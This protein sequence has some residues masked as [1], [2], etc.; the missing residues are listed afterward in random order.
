MIS[1]RS[2]LLSASAPLLLQGMAQPKQPENLDVL[3]IGAGLAGLN[4][5]MLLEG[6]GAR[7]RVLEA[8][9]RVGGRVRSLTHLEGA[10]EAGGSLIG[11]GYGRLISRAAELG[12][13]LKTDQRPGALYDTRYYIGGKR[14]SLSD[15]EKSD[16]NPFIGTD[17]GTPPGRIAS[18]FSSKTN[19]LT[20]ITDWRLLENA[21]HDRSVY[22]VLAASGFN[23]AQIQLATQIN[24][25]YLGSPHAMSMLMLWQIDA[26][27]KSQLA[28]GR[29]TLGAKGGNDAIP[30]AMAA[31][32]K[33]DVVLNAPVKTISH[34]GAG[35]TVTLHDG[36]V[37][38]ARRCIVTVPLS[39]L[40]FVRFDP[41]LPSV[42][43]AAINQM[44]Y[45]KVVQ[46]HLRPTQPYWERDGQ[47]I[48]MWTDS[49]AGRV[50]GIPSRTGDPSAPPDHLVVFISGMQAAYLDRLP[51]VVAQQHILN[52]LFR[53]RPAMAGAVEP[54][55]FVSWQRDPY[56]GGSYV[57]WGP[58]HIAKFANE[59]IKPFGRIVLAGEH[60][61]RTQR[62]MEGAME[63]GE[64]AALGVLETL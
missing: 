34:D 61:A 46:L 41:V 18:V 16:T 52:E 31:A 45:T 9:G 3:I 6:E 13:E 11:P 8:R 22:E 1:R 37:H 19:P 7:I 20:G 58:G 44:Q 49:G 5:A 63:A 10:P 36:A 32:L 53:L 28:A 2:F 23:D 17:R 27:R 29:V 40:G 55:A 56:A 62:G 59:I 25:A 4:A 48:G 24:P 51:G 57:G 54:V 35:V 26:W 38:K 47:P 50:F 39:A 60:T 33:G 21:V 14:F 64:A 12:V 15:W 43:A 30:K 42:H